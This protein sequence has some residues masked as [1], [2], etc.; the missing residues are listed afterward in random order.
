MLDKN[1][2]LAIREVV[3][4]IVDERV[5]QSENLILKYV[6]DTRA[7]LEEKIQKVQDN[8]DEIAQ[9]YRIRRLEDE[10]TSYLVKNVHE[11]TGRVDVLEKKVNQAAAV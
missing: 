10:T 7:V 3:E 2:L 9:Y 8:V 6:D 4:E 5:T 1:D 11:L